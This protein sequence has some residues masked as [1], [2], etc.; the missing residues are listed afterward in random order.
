VRNAG[1]HVQV[2]Q[3]CAAQLT[4]YS[5]RWPQGSTQAFTLRTVCRRALHVDKRASTLTARVSRAGRVPSSDRRFREAL[6]APFWT[7]LHPD[8]TDRLWRALGQPGA[9]PGPLSSQCNC[10]AMQHG[11]S[12]RHPSTRS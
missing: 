3:A 8:V 7:T 10:S 12:A 6:E 9:R 11:P 4:K 2:L 1:Q 5:L